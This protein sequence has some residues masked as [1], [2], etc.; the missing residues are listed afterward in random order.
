VIIT[1]GDVHKINKRRVDRFWELADQAGR[2]DLKPEIRNGPFDGVLGAWNNQPAFVV[3]ASAAGRGFD[4]KLLD[5]FNSIGVNHM[6]EYYDGFKWFLFMDQRFLR[7]TTYNLNEYK[8]KIFA[9][10]RVNMSTRNFPNLVLFR[11][12]PIQGEPD[13]NISNGLYCR[14]LSGMSALH[15]AI[16]SGANPIYMIGLDSVKNIDPTKGFH[17]D[18]N[19]TGEEKS[20]KSYNGYTKISA[21]FSKFAQWKDK[22]IN[23]CPDGHIDDFKKISVD[24]LTKIIKGMKNEHRDN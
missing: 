15:L 24:E 14:S 20:E 10:N 23:V 4:L 16:I 11:C 1:S 7:L 17:Y 2:I 9:Y 22:I 18:K 12:K 5:G 3:G 19:Y 13:Y 21:S 6:I 8:G